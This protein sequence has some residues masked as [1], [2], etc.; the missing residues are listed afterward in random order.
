M[1]PASQWTIAF[2]PGRGA[3]TG[4]MPLPSFQSWAESPDAGIRYFSGTATYKTQIEAKHAA[5]ERVFLTLTDLHEVCT[6]RINGKAA[7]TIWA[8]PYRLDITDSLADGR[9]TLELDVTNLWP[10]RLIGDSQP[11]VTRTYT[12]TNIRKYTADSP[13]LPSGLIGPVAL[14]TVHETRSHAAQ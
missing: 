6:V 2:Q 1:L 13:L 11:G 7:G 10:N 3:P 4:T 9:N 14:E 12:H 8:M 5:G